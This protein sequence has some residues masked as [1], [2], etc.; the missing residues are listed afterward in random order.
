MRSSHF[1]RSFPQ[2]GVTLLEALIALLIV[3]LGLLAFTGLQA[4]MRINSDI[5]KQRSEAV[6]IAQENMENLRAYGTLSGDTSIANN[7]SYDAGIVNNAAAKAVLASSVSTA[8][9]TTYTVTQSVTASTSPGLKDLRVAVAWTDRENNPQQVVLRS[10][11][12]RSDPRLAAA[13]SIP[14]NGSPVKDPLGRDVRVPIPSRD[15]GDGTSVFKPNAS[16]TLAFVFSNDTGEITRRCQGSSLGS[17]T[18]AQMTA[19]DLTSGICESVTGY[20][21]SGYVRYSLA[22]NPDASSPNDE[23]VDNGNLQV[24][25]DLDSSNPPAGAVGTQAQLTAAYWPTLG[26]TVNHSDYPRSPDCVTQNSITV[27]FTTPVNYSQVNNGQT[28]T[29]TSSQV[30]AIV[31]A[32]TPITAA[33][34]APHVNL[35]PTAVQNPTD[36]GERYVA[37]TCVV[38]PRDFGGRIAWTGRSLVVPSTNWSIGTGNSQYKVCRYSEDYNLNG[39]VWTVSGTNVAKIDNS[40]HP[41]AYLQA[42]TGLN[43]QNFLI[44]RGN[45][46]C[47]TDGPFE[48]DGRGGENY[49]NETTVIHQ[50]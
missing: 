20:L 29:V 2:R 42:S 5:A 16:G 36:L 44:V 38:Y 40:E 15:L 17:I 22:N 7:F 30:F 47:P 35:D 4:R 11:I 50:S 49:T 39:Y 31:P 48:V 41:Y 43:N 18:T 14:P 24:R 9:N 25:L 21:L 3:A 26:Q 34:I 28:Q 37:Y 8:T 23:P 12:G 10:V 46:S 19:T 45:R 32:G 6:R 33:G 13:L 1:R 27:R